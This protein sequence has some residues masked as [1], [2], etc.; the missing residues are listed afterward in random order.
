MELARQKLLRKGKLM[1]NRTGQRR[2]G[3]Q[4]KKLREQG[5]S[6]DEVMRRVPV[7]GTIRVSGIEA[8]LM[9]KAQSEHLSD[10][11]FN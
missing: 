4:R 10:E 9:R 8:C 2:R 7:P 1:T 6:E 5:L 3:R 11:N